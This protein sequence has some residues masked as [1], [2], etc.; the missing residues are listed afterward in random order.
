MDIGQRRPRPTLIHCGMHAA[1]ELDT[2]SRQPLYVCCDHSSSLLDRVP[3]D[4]I[5]LSPIRFFFL[6]DRGESRMGKGSW[7]DGYSEFQGR[8][9]KTDM[10]VLFTGRVYAVRI[11]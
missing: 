11:R 1:I 10:L 6:T 5:T 3:G 2:P 7:Y 4:L 9:E 8:E